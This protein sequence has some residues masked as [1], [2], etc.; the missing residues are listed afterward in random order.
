MRDSNNK[1]LI[2]TI[3]TQSATLIL[4]VIFGVLRLLRT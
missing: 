2:A 1:I 4:T 3:V